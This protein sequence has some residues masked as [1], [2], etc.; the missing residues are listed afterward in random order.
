M[1]DKEY[2][3]KE[4]KEYH[5]LRSTLLENA[6]YFEP[7]LV[8]VEDCLQS[9][10]DNSIDKESDTVIPLLTIPLSNSKLVLSSLVGVYLTKK[11][12][13]FFIP[14]LYKVI[15]SGDQEFIKRY[16]PPLNY[17]ELYKALGLLNDSTIRKVLSSDGI[18]EFNLLYEAY[19]KDR[20][21]F[22]NKC[23]ELQ[24]SE[25]CISIYSAIYV[26]PE[27]YETIHSNFINDI[28]TN[29]VAGNEIFVDDFIQYGIENNKSW[30]NIWF[31]DTLDT[32]EEGLKNWELLARDNMSM[33]RAGCESL[34]SNRSLPAVIQFKLKQEWEIFSA[35]FEDYEPI[36]LQSNVDENVVS[37]ICGDTL[38][39][40]L[41]NLIDSQSPK[42]REE[43]KISAKAL[44]DADNL[45]T[46][47]VKLGKSRILIDGNRTD[48]KEKIYREALEILY[49]FLT[50][51]KRSVIDLKRDGQSVNIGPSLECTLE[52]FLFLFDYKGEKLN[53]N[54]QPILNWINTTAKAPKQEFIALL[55][56]LYWDENGKTEDQKKQYAPS[57]GEQKNL[58]RVNSKSIN[59]LS[60]NPSKVN[61]RIDA[62]IEL[63]KDCLKKA[64]GRYTRGEI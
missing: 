43:K 27:F 23:Q 28:V 37:R 34:I 17:E 49:D 58:C 35:F 19:N 22:I 20:K 8:G 36:F 31:D 44:I 64:T 53:I 13:E 2:L 18:S 16:F 47:F 45:E 59:K 21:T 6:P 41:Q 24:I 33:V 9:L 55:Y 38:F 50:E 39:H 29:A 3:K 25:A 52:E 12:N 30:V 61:A 5:S 42:F 63:L 60:E 15:D 11:L 26:V 48:H 56:A 4:F 7:V 57:T 62:W 14:Y 1:I 46:N 10:F 40:T 54:S 51:N 32:S